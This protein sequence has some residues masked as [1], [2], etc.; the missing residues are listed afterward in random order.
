M[1][2]QFEGHPPLLFDS[3]HRTTLQLQGSPLIDQCTCS[4]Y[5][6]GYPKNLVQVKNKRH[7]SVENASN[8]V[9]IYQ[10]TSR[11]H[12]SPV[13]LTSPYMSLTVSIEFWGEQSTQIVMTRI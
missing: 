11:R 1:E 5:G 12:H 6:S 10:I 9:K 13:P 2:P 8:I 7:E 4:G 3:S